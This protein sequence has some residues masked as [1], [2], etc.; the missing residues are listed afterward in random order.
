VALLDSDFRESL[1]KLF[2][3]D[4]AF[5]RRKFYERAHACGFA[6]RLGGPEM[7]R[8]ARAVELMQSNMPLPAVQMLLGHA[9]PTLTSAYVSPSAEELREVT[10]FFVE[11]ESARKTSARNAFFGKIETIR[12]GDIQTRVELTTIAGHAITTVITNDSLER[13]GLR[14]G[15]LVTA[16]VKAPWVILQQGEDEPRCSAEN[17]CK[18]IIVRALKGGINTEYVVRLADGTELCSIVTSENCRRHD[19]EEG[20]MVWALFNSFSVV[21]HVE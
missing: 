15:M 5:V 16:E 13:L 11:R 14:R 6:K 19:L 12:R 10:R 18:G 17:R 7:I 20:A 4:P 1:Q 8:K 3:V 2:A 21:L 9:T